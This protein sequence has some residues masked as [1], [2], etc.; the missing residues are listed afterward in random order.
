VAPPKPRVPRRAVWRWQDNAGNELVSARGDLQGAIAF[1]AGQS[2]V[3]QW[4]PRA[5]MLGIRQR[6]KRNGPTLRLTMPDGRQL[7]VTDPGEGW[8]GEMFAVC[9][10]GHVSP[11]PKH[12]LGGQ[13]G[14]SNE[15]ALESAAR[16][17]SSRTGREEAEFI[18]TSVRDFQRSQL[19]QRSVGGDKARRISS[20]DSPSSH[21]VV[22]SNVT[23]LAELRR[24]TPYR[25]NPPT[26]RD[27]RRALVRSHGFRTA[28]ELHEIHQ[29]VKSKKRVIH[30]D[31]E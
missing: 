1:E 4:V 20:S 31:S 24:K 3:V 27:G 5:E 25:A 11:A 17:L 28:G 9:D 23:G 22:A 8:T 7:I 14:H 16:S 21:R 10:R 15:K 12:S 26:D 18:R 30:S 13:L 29:R 6:F 19:P 2:V